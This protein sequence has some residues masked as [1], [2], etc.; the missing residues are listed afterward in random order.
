MKKSDNERIKKIIDIWSSLQLQ[1]KEHSITKEN[2]LNDEF[3]QWAVTTPLYNIGEQVYKISD[4]TKKQ[5]PDIIWSIV[6]GLRHRLVHDYEGINW[7]II[8]EVIFDEM[9]DFVNSIKQ[10]IE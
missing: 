4:D 3:L 7:S 2:L 5:Y 9:D 6:A 10:I 1:I 8:V